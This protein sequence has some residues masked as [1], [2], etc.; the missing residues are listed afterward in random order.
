MRPPLPCPVCDSA[1]VIIVAG[2]RGALVPCPRCVGLDPH[3]IPADELAAIIARVRAADSTW[4]LPE[5]ARAIDAPPGVELT[6]PW[7]TATGL[8][9]RARAIRHRIRHRKDPHR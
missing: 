9:Q 5:W 6:A 3:G 1:H 4:T 8:R 7:Y 2:A